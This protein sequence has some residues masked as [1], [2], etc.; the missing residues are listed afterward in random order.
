ML[1]EDGN[2]GLDE[3]AR[4]IALAR[5]RLP[6]YA[7]N[8]YVGNSWDWKPPS[9]FQYVYTLLDAVPPTYEGAHLRRLLERVVAPGGRLIAG[10]YGSRSRGIPP[11]ARTEGDVPDAVDEE[12][13]ERAYRFCLAVVDELDADL[14][15]TSPT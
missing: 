7:A 13:M 11:R 2:N 6:E 5:Q 3:G 14:A 15:A 1:D 10:D 12:A 8:L 9:R 4:L